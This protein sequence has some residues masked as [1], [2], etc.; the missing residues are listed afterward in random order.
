MKD[1]SNKGR[2]IGLLNK[3]KKEL[4]P[5]C[6][7]IQEQMINDTGKNKKK[8]NQYI[9]QLIYKIAF[10]CNNADLRLNYVEAVEVYS[11]RE[12]TKVI[13]DKILGILAMINSE[14]GIDFDLNK[15]TLCM[16]MG[17][18]VNTYQ[19]FLYNLTLESN[20]IFVDI[21]EF[22]ITVKTTGAENGVKNVRAVENTLSMDSRYGG[23][24]ISFD[25]NSISPNG[26]VSKL[27]DPT[28]ATEILE[29]KYNDL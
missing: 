22:L 29:T 1:T 16:L 15:K 5:V 28:K 20:S 18:S 8:E 24:G 9:N 6:A 14:Y 21:E 11:S 12:N 25:K 10:L 19:E 13:Y 17:I 26:R 23:H 4:M 7:N 2:I 3:V 27:S